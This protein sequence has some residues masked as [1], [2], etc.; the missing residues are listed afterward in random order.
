MSEESIFKRTITPVSIALALVISILGLNKFFVPREV[1]QVQ[2]EAAD[3]RFNIQDQRLKNES[4][5]RQIELLQNQKLYYEAREIN[6]MQMQRYERDPNE[7]VKMLEDIK[8]MRH[9]KD[10]I[11][12]KIF[13]LKNK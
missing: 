5:T 1:Y 7:K 8:R 13:K 6:L 10:K 3:K 2:C 11:D 4:M 9:E 12:D